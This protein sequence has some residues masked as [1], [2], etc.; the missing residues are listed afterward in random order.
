MTYA[1]RG[2]ESMRRLRQFHAPWP[3]GC[4]NGAKDVIFLVV[5]SDQIFYGGDALLPKA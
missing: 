1:A 2:L 3:N 4:A 5:G